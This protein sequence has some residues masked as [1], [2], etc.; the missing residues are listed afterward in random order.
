MKIAILNDTHFGARNDSSVFLNY[1][2]S[3]F[4]N[5]FFP[6]LEKN[7][8]KNI[9]HLGDF[10]DRRKYVN[11]NTLSILK[12]RFFSVLKDYNFHMVLGNHDTFY[13]NTN[14]VNSAS[15]LFKFYDFFNLHEKPSVLEFDGLNIGMVP[16]ICPENK[17]TILDFLKTCDAP[18][19]C[20]H[21]ELS[22]YEV[23]RGMNFFGGMDDNCLSR[24]EKVLSGHFHIKS[25]KKNVHYLGTQ[26]QMTFADLDD[27]KGF[28]V[29]D[30]ET[31]E[32]EFIENPDKMFYSFSSD[33][34]FSDFSSLKDKMV[35]LTYS[36]DDSRENIDSFI[37]NIENSNPYDFTIIENFVTGL[38]EKNTVDLSKDT[39]SI[40]NEEI[41]N[42]E[43]DIN[44]DEIKKITH[45]IYMEALDQ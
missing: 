27:V 12:D 16:W 7:N 6:Y 32:L 45:E 20:G 40:I 14:K 22:G 44:K 29:I 42:L 43:I 21:F 23:L 26:Y 8:I 39:L 2:L 25:T 41:Q 28:H 35:K 17:D 13:R 4:E 5:Q 37:K 31:R 18:I 3:F 30:T 10:M 1:F 15:E 36:S 9:L 11:F 38:S 33:S 19:I 24:F 34:D